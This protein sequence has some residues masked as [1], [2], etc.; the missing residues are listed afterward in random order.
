MNPKKSVRFLI[1]AILGLAVL[2]PG[3]TSACAVCFGKSDSLLAVGMNWG[4][5]TLLFFIL[6]VLA[7][8]SLFFVFLNRRAQ[9]FPLS[10]DS[11]NPADVTIV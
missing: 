8:I 7:V 5:L 3:T 4:I 10:V 9:Q 11:A 1:G 2:S 6:S